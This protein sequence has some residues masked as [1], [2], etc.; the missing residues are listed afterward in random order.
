MSFFYHMSNFYGSQ[1]LDFVG[2]FLFVGWAIGMNLIRMDKL[3]HL[4]PFLILFTLLNTII[5]HVMYVEE[6]KFQILILFSA[7]CI[8]FTE[9]NHKSKWFRFSL[10]LFIIAFG[11]SVSDAERLFCHGHAFWHVIAS[12]G[13]FALYKHYEY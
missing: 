3:K 1:I 12:A 6:I 7:L 2:M 10:V 8:L 5:M 9:K 13:V 11:F 4:L